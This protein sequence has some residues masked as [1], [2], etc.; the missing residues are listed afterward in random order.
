MRA[1]NI[2]FGAEYALRDPPKLGVE[3]QRVRVLAQVRKQWKVQ[4]IDPNPGLV[5]FVRSICLVAPW[6]DLGTIP[7][8]ADTGRANRRKQANHS[9]P[10][11][12]P[13]RSA[14]RQ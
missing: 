1:E 2:E 3:L 9:E 5:D 6:K 13:H 4:W 12:G 7:R 10:G 14:E 8:S 11:S